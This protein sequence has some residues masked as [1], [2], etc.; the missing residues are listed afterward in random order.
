MPAAKPV[1]QGAFADFMARAWFMEREAS[2]RYREMAEQLEGHGNREC[3]MLFRK[4]AQA[5]GRH[6]DR[7]QAEMGW[8]SPPALPATFAWEGDEAPETADVDAVFPLIQPM[9]A[10]VLALDG[11]LRAQRYFEKIASG[12]A[13]Q[14]VRVAAAEMATEERAHAKLIE[15]WLARLPRPISGWE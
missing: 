10:L 1:P 15:S 13:P 2:A 7:I 11:E 5:E 3:A 12:S 6:A 8:T 9:Q 14:S 4:L